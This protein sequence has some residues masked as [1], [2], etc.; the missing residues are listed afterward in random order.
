[1]WCGAIRCTITCGVVMPFCGRFWCGFCGLYSLCG[2]VNT[3]TTS[4]TSLFVAEKP[5]L[6]DF[7]IVIIS[8]DIRTSPTP[9]LLWFTTPSTYTFQDKGSC[10]EIALTNFS[11][12]FCFST[13]SSTGISAN[14]ATRS[15]RTWPLIEVQGMYLISKAPRIVPHFAILPV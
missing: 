1:M 4:R 3:P 11:S 7:L 13:L 10:K 12:M 2:L 9:N 14:L 15:A 6:R 5:N 8:R